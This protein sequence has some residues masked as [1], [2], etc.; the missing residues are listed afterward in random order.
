MPLYALDEENRIIPAHEADAFRRYR[1]LECQTALQKRVGPHRQAH[2]YH[3]QTI[4]QCRLHSRSV[5]H[6][7]FQS[8]LCELNSALE[9]E[10]PFE[11]ILRI[12]DLCWEDQKLVFEIQ[13]SPIDSFQARQR[14]SDYARE[15]Y[16]LVWLLDDRIYNRKKALRFAET[17]LRRQSGYYFS[18]KSGV[19]YDQFDVIANDRRLSRGPPL[20]VALDRPSPKTVHQGQ[21]TQQLNH[22]IGRRFFAG[23]L[24]DRALSFPI[25][26]QRLQE[27]EEQI[28]SEHQRKNGIVQWMKKGFYVALECVLR[29]QSDG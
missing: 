24:F 2:F 10:R 18:L 14:A 5:D 19:V 8:H 9:I 29:K 15:G 7:V 12:A 28:L 1:C 22:R 13:C 27:H 4:R 11:K 3:L 17:H 21:W 16:E 25:Y 23:D 26:L 20:P 6:L